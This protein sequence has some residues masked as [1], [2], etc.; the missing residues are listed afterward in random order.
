MKV[1]H[2][3]FLLSFFFCSVLVSCSDQESNI[4]SQVASRPIS[5]IR[6]NQVKI[7]EQIWMTKNLNVSRYR[8]G[9]VIP[10][11]TNP[12]QWANLTTGA[13]CYYANNSANGVVYGK[14]YNGYAVN[15]P[16]GLAPVGYHIP[17]DLEWTLLTISLGGEDI[18]GDKM[19]ATTSWNLFPGVINNNSS[20]FTGLS[21]GYRTLDGSFYNMGYYNSW[22]SSSATDDSNIWYRFVK[23][24]S[25]WVDRLKNSP[26]SGFSVRCVKD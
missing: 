26:N 22:W 12:Q 14:L 21:G 20:G 17:T 13:W 23:Y 15:D 6:I 3:A 10:Q 24:N 19:K 18:A 25:S 5:P 11:V 8:N 16:R 4:K 9:D 7:G 2:F 1:A